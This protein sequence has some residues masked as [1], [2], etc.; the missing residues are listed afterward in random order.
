[1]DLLHVAGWVKQKKK[2]R[3]QM[4]MPPTFSSLKGGSKR[5]KKMHAG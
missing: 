4:S 5:E 3:I 1:M 2:V